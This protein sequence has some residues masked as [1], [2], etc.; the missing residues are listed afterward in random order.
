MVTCQKTLMIFIT[1]FQI[2][3]IVE[4]D[5]INFFLS[6]YMQNLIRNSI[7][8]LKE[9]PVCRKQACLFDRR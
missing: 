3:Q 6:F 7:Y 5:P 1:V 2:A 8:F 9:H 4:M